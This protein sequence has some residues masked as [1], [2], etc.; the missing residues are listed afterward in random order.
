MEV[1]AIIHFPASIRCSVRDSLR[2]YRNNGVDRDR[3]QAGGAPFH[4]LLD[5]SGPA[6]IPHVLLV[7]EDGPHR[8]V[9]LRFLETG[10]RDHAPRCRRPWAA[11]RDP[12][13]I[14]S[15]A[16]GGLEIAENFRSLPIL[17]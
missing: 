8:A 5:R 11:P 2:S 14:P 7:R 13:V 1:D 3:G 12:A 4:F 6:A 10:D 15:P 9:P 17:L 16:R